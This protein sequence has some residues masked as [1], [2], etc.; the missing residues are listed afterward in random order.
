MKALL[1][2]RFRGKD[3]VL[4]NLKVIKMKKTD[5]RKNGK[6]HNDNQNFKTNHFS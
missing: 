2:R 3:M 4:L 6:S 1:V 5:T